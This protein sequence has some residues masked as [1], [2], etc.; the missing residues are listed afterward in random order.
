MDEPRSDLDDIVA[1]ARQRHRD[2]AL[3]AAAELYDSVLAIDP[4]NAEVL[5]LKGILLAQSGAP[6]E[7]LHLLERSVVLAP[8]DGRIRS[9]LAKLRLDLGDID[10][11]VLDYE[12]ARQHDP[13]D[14]VLEFNLAGALAL[15]GRRDA[16]IEHLEHARDLSPG[17][18]HVLANLGNLYRQVDRLE[19]S[20]DALE[21]A[22]EASPDDPEVQHSLGITLAGLHEYG[23]GAARFRQALKLDPG[24]VRAAAQLFYA[25]LHACDWADH[26]KLIAN[27]ERLLDILAAH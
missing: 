4:E 25:T 3:D 14:T 12:A 16:A 15:A 8:E 20:R 5:Q 6:E 11:A 19:A 23:A 10:G 17:H 24:F 26:P 21:E 18:A 27:F 7:G 9:N 1:D 13:D 2:G 22:V